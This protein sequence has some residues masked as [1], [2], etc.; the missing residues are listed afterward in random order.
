MLFPC[1]NMYR[2]GEMTL[3]K[4]INCSSRE[5]QVPHTHMVV[6]NWNSSPRDILFTSVS[7]ARIEYT[8]I[9][10]GKTLIHTKIKILNDR[11]SK[12]YICS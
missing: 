12:E 3:V 1:E 4:S 8:D 6:I 9:H 11:K 5:P 10:V 2:A 7:T